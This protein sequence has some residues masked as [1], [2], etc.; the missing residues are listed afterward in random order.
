MRRGAEDN[1]EPTGQTPRNIEQRRPVLGEL[2]RRTRG[3]LGLTI[4]QA[5]ERAPMSPETWRKA[6]I[7]VRVKPFSVAAI[8]RVLGWAPGSGQ[9]YLESGEEP[10]AQRSAKSSA[11][12]GARAVVD[13]DAVLQLQQ[14]DTVK[15]RLIEAV[16]SGRDPIDAIL[17]MQID[18]T[19]KVQLIEVY[20]DV[21]APN[22]RERREDDPGARS[23]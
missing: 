18:A 14:S 5:A 2:I 17:G 22:G 20:R 13:I 23:A 9:A 7:G 10:V 3:A 12:A 8:E 11:G 19:E 16:T 21:A 6:E 15:L 1:H 4:D